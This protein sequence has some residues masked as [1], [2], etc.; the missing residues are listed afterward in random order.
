MIRNVNPGWIIAIVTYVIYSLPT[1]IATLLGHF[2]I[3]NLGFA[4]LLFGWGSTSLVIILA[5]RMKN[6][7]LRFSTQTIHG[8]GQS[9]FDGQL[10]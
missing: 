3:S 4:S 5:H 1:W 2:E 8:A 7:R 9:S 10:S 6:E